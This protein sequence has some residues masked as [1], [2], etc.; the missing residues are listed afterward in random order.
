M[1]GRMRHQEFHARLP[2]LFDGWGTTSARPRDGRFARLAGSLRCLS[3]PGTLRLLNLAVELLE[4]G[5]VYCEAGS[6]RGC[7][8]AG[9][10]AGNESAS[11]LALDDFSEFDADDAGR[12]ELES[13]LERFGL[14]SRVDLRAVAFER[15]FLEATPAEHPRIGVYFYDAAHDHRSQLRGLLLAAPFLADRALVVV[16][17]TN[18]AAPRRAVAD[19]CAWRPEA[20][21]TLD[22]PT[23]T[24]DHPSFWNGLQVLTWERPHPSGP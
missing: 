13:N 19:F 22:L 17:D 2:S 11:A 15:H 3:A 5:E 14:R 7:T 12:A 1:A 23:P 9:A 6:Y 10:L 21:M 20:R 16:D 18:W 24:L 4:P 8:L